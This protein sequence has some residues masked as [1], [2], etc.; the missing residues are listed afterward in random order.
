MNRIAVSVRP[1]LWVLQ[2]GHFRIGEHHGSRGK[3]GLNLHPNVVKGVSV[4]RPAGME[5]PP[6]EDDFPALDLVQP[7][8]APDGVDVV[9]LPFRKRPDSD[10]HRSAARLQGSQI[11]P[12]LALGIGIEWQAK[13]ALGWTARQQA[14]RD[15]APVEQTDASCAERWKT[16]RTIRPIPDI[17]GNVASASRMKGT[18]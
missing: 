10:E 8:T 6:D 9:Q 16:A 5:V 17:H 13:L 11:G 18:L 3:S 7:Q 12:N 15:R 2:G 1:P 4:L 14:E